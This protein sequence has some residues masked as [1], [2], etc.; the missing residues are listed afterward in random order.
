LVI[1]QRLGAIVSPREPLQLLR[2]SFFGVTTLTVGFVMTAMSVGYLFTLLQRTLQLE[3]LTTDLQ[4][5]TE[6]ITQMSRHDALT[7]MPNRVLF[8]E[9]M[10]QALARFRRGAPFALLFLDLDR[11]KAVNDTLGHGAG[12]QLLCAV[13]GRINDCIRETDTAARL[14]GD[15]FAVLLADMADSSTISVVANQQT[16][17]DRN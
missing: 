4:A 13:A 8:Q 10:E 15:E 12:D 6:Q 11:F 2:L 7:G 16:V 9:R 17:H 14:G 3:A 5:S 1:D